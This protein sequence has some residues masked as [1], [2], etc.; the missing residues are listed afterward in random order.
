MAKITEAQ[1]EMIR[2]GHANG[3]SRKKL[4]ALYGVTTVTIGHI[5]RRLT[6]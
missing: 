6:H 4:A 2:I 1:A 3:I 5:I